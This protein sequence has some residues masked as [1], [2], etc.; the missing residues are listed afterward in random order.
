MRPTLAT[1]PT[2]EK[3]KL[4]AVRADNP[5][6]MTHTGTMTYLLGEGDVVVID[7]GPDLPGHAAALLSRLGP[8]ER[9]VAL[10]ATHAHADHVAGL[11]RLQS[12][13]GAPSFGFGPA[14]S[15]QSETMRALVRKGLPDAGE[16]FDRQFSPD[17][18]L[19]DSQTF[20]PAGFQI[21]ALHT[22][23]HTGCSLSFS[24]G[25]WLFTGDL[26]MGWASSLISP[27]NGDMSAYIASL[28]RLSQQRWSRLFPG[29]GP[30]VQDAS[31]RLA[32]LIT[33]RRTREAQVMQALAQGLA[34][35]PAITASIY[36]DT[37]AALRTAAMHNVLAHLIDLADKGEVI[38]TPAPLPFA[39]FRRV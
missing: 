21:T 11:P 28:T 38:A 13:T 22:P 1:D 6:P 3:P 20:S 2:D 30:A 23:G 33:H 32:E 17:L 29:H 27:P 4:R 19:A 36:L 8:K 10:L 39:R 18:R 35:I 7:P 16:G 9:I 37:P 14:G 5:S 31:A 34:D 26:A 25:D 15:G 24:V 12:L